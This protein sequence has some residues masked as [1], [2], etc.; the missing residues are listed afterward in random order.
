[1]VGEGVLLE[2]LAHPHVTDVLSVSR[3][4]AAI[5]H[6]K[7]KQYIVPDFLK[8][9]EG[10]EKLQGYD[11][12]FFCAGVSSIGMKEPQYTRLT[13][14]TTLAFAKA[15]H[16]APHLS[17]VYVSGS[18]TDS[19]EKG[20]LMWARV[21]GRTENDLMRLPFKQVFAFRPGFM[22]ATEGQRYVLKYY[23]YFAWLYPVLKVVAPNAVNTL[24]QVG[25]AM[26]YAAR[27]GYEKAV[28]EV[29]DITILADR[30]TKQTG[31]K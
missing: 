10:D 22:K 26:I 3:R 9:Q 29:K 14:D 17:F 2:C 31:K 30:A 7:L 25:Q 24:R 23:K 4:P 27:Y 20:R 8:L 12:C 13:Y 28:V 16:P 1:M 6:P 18:G 19:S 21:K 11:A 5:T 15:L